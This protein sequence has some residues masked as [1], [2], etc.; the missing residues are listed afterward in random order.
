MPPLGKP[1]FDSD[2]YL[3]KIIRG[4]GPFSLFDLPD[5][6]KNLV[7]YRGGNIVLFAV[8]DD[9][10]CEILNFRFP[11]PLKG[12]AAGGF[13]FPVFIPQHP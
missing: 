5:H 13:E 10:T 8:L 7:V 1:L 12:L 9:K 2:S 11:A 6:I 4:Y 3:I